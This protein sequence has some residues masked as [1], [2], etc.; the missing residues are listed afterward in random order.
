MENIF[1]KCTSVDLTSLS[2]EIDDFD[3]SLTTSSTC[4]IKFKLAYAINLTSWFDQTNVGTTMVPI[5][6]NHGSMANIKS[7]SSLNIP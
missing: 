2:N 4:S 7:S 3:I 6:N 1:G 5:E